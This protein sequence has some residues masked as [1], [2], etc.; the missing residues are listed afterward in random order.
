MGIS[1]RR[2]R[3]VSLDQIRLSE[4]EKDIL[5]VIKRR[6]GL[7]NWNIPCRWALC[8]S[9]AEPSE[10]PAV[11]I[12]SDSNV[13]MSWKTFG[14]EHAEIFRAL[15]LQ[16]CVDAGDEPNDEN[17]TR[18]FRLHLNRGLSYLRG[19]DDFRSLPGVLRAATAS[20]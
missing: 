17:V 20:S 7:R 2:R 10:P 5:V 3:R 8:L 18:T 4:A 19:N 6:T 14:G 11:T 12:L 13:E 15:V 1:G 16:R 9:L